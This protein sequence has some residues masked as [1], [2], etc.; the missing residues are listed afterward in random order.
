[1]RRR[2]AT[3]GAGR[4]AA[5]L[6]ALGLL[7]ALAGCGTTEP[8]S[9]AAH[10]FGEPLDAGVKPDEAGC[11]TRIRAEEAVAAQIR[12]TLE[13]T[14][15]K[16]DLATVKAVAADPMADVATYGFPVT[17]TEAVG[18]HANGF[19][20]DTTMPIAM[21]V[22]VGAP[23][24]F[25][26]LWFDGATAMVAIVNGDPATLAVARCLER[27]MP[28]RYVWTAT[29]ELAGEALKD[30]VGAD[31]NAWKARGVAVNMVDFD[32]TKGVVTIGV[33]VVDD[34]LRRLFFETYGPLVLLVVEGPARPL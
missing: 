2:S 20:L 3:T 32:E 16:S 28:V 10:V 34:A 18:L 31:I 11:Q 9:A 7:V 6:L 29:S 13:K 5:A 25:G 12:A 17:Q 30:R 4:V 19:D 26:G 8:P 22:Q 1:M 15:L 23:D 33:T 14:G 24:R 21:W 27:E